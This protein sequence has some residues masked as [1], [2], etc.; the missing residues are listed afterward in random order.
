MLRIRRILPLV[1]ILMFLLP[2]L[3]VAAEDEEAAGQAA[4]Q[5]GKPRI[6]LSHYVA[7]LQS[8]SGGSDADQR[9]REKIIALALKLTPPPAASLEAKKHMARGQAA[10]EIAQKPE[11]L[12]LAL[13]E[14]RQASLAAPWWPDA[15]YNL[16]QV[17][18]K[19]GNFAQGLRELRWYLKAAPH[20]TDSE[21]VE[22]QIAKLELKQEQAA[23]AQ[24]EAARARQA[25]EEQARADERL[26]AQL[27]GVWHD[28]PMQSTNQSGQRVTINRGYR[29]RIRTEGTKVYAT[30]IGVPQSNEDFTRSWYVTSPG[31]PLPYIEATIRE[32]RLIGT[33]NGIW[34]AYDG[35]G[36][37][38]TNPLD[39]KITMAYDGRSLTVDSGKG[40]PWV[41]VKE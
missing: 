40:K 4:E 17:Q 38:D 6:A 25:E 5:A 35:A 15:Y 24:A 7:A 36:I 27:A 31:L 33:V 8:A 20:A 37:Q 11:D 2:A 26:A 13:S 10:L 41:W 14:F 39:A 1:I 29:I 18:E 34:Y 9:L 21:A 12:Q 3:P 28:E 22:L 32:G 23:K 16:A 30:C 19:V